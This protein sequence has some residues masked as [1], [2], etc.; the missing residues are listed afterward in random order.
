MGYAVFPAGQQ[1]FGAPSGRDPN[2]SIFRP[3]ASSRE[4]GG[5]IWRYPPGSHGRRHGERVQ[6]EV[7]V[8]LEGTATVYLDDPAEPFELPRG[9]VAVVEA[10]TAVQVAN[11]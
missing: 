9:S 8:V 4:T 6:E 11:H 2:G 1:E 5:S 10:G 3:R 7:F